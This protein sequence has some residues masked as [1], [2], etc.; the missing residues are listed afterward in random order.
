MNTETSIEGLDRQAVHNQSTLSS[1]SDD[2]QLGTNYNPATTEH[3]AIRSRN[4]TADGSRIV[5]VNS[6]P[7]IPPAATNPTEEAHVEAPNPMLDGSALYKAMVDQPSIQESVGNEHDEQN[8][9]VPMP[10]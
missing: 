1:N 5:A 2:N 4:G 3:T 7:P 8:L 9:I 10:L 6:S